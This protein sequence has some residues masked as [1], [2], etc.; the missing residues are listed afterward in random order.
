MKE[1]PK[2][3]MGVG[4]RFGREGEAQ[5]SV[6]AELA[7][8]GILV[9]PVWNKSNREHTLI[10]THPDDL[11]AEAEEAVRALGWKGPH[12]VDADHINLHTVD[13]FI[14]AS[15]FFT[16][17]VA[18]YVGKPA[19]PERRA[20][21]LE[22]HGALRGTRAMPG[23]DAPLE[24]SRAEIEGAADKFL[25]AMQEAGRIHRHIAAAKPGGA[26]AVEVSVDETDQPQK[27][28]ELLAI[29]AMIADEGI[30]AQT[31]APKFTG[32][33]NKGVDYVGDIAA[34]EREF[35]ADLAVLRF[36]VE[37]FGLPPSLKVS[38]HSGSDKFSLYPIIR[39]LLAK[40]GAGLH[41][42]TAGTTWLE[43]VIGLAESGGA[44]LQL[45]K[46]LY[47]AALPRAEELIKPYAPV[48][49]IRVARLPSAET[50]N[51][52]SSA[53]YVAALN[54]DPAHP[55]FDVGFRQ[56]MHVSFRIAAEMG[57]RF[58]DALAA[59]R[60]VI[61]RRVRD[62]LLARHANPLFG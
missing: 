43:E 22:K 32:R 50:V 56:F 10:G 33:F 46:E 27:P 37:S 18:D 29:L 62:N 5:L 42:K 28:G 16:I 21:F 31:L 48:V 23:L 15:D 41:L 49:D 51:G 34:F 4:D 55:R 39:R 26:F 36:A 19:S 1:L 24:I 53:E 58:T 17:D 11:R 57:A 52:W 44:A 35:D 13:R 2:F 20:A 54:H 7:A 60:A 30:P 61:A 3:S 9:A 12:F 6:F 40:R 25:W 14:G 38:V 8:R 59:H 45:A 47:A